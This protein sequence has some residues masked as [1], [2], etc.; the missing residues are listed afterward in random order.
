MNIRS[1]YTCAHIPR[2]VRKKHVLPA[3]PQPIAGYGT[4]SIAV[5]KLT[6]L[7]SICGGRVSEAPG[8][9][10]VGWGTVIL[11]SLPYL[12]CQIFPKRLHQLRTPATRAER[13]FLGW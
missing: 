9:L 7:L 8:P 13:V 5:R 2:R 10:A 6:T 4:Q 3:S 1:R 12:L 11:L